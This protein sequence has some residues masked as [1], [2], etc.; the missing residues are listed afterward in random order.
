MTQTALKNWHKLFRHTCK[1]S[2]IHR[3]EGF[4]LHFLLFL[5]FFKINYQKEKPLAKGKP[6][7]DLQKKKDFWN[8]L[9]SVQIHAE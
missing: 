9:H 8:A 2:G 5:Y 3:K 4:A 1:L 7:S 6:I